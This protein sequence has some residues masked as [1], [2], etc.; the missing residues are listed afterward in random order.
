MHIQQGCQ[1]YPFPP[2]E[3]Y[4]TDNTTACADDGWNTDAPVCDSEC[5][6]D[7]SLNYTKD[8]TFGNGSYWVYPNVTQLQLE[9]MINGPVVGQFLVYSDFVNYKKGKIKSNIIRLSFHKSYSKKTQPTVNSR[10]ICAL[11]LSLP[12]QLH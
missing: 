9:I 3:H 1:A 12:C 11:L 6:A 5:T 10:H 8:L 7:T 4:G 2:C